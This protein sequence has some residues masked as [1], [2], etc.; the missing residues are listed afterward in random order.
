[1]EGEYLGEY[2]SITSAAKSLGKTT[3]SQ[4]QKSCSGKFSLTAYGYVW[5]YKDDDNI[6]EIVSLLKTKNKVGVNK[7]SV[8]QIDEN[9]NVVAE[10]ESASAAGRALGKAHVGIAKAAR[11]GC[12]AYGYH[13]KYIN[14]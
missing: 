2:P 3:V 6:E 12:T 11:E 13:W 10:Y 5:Q 8:Q 4:I 1:M 7:K 9:G 14:K